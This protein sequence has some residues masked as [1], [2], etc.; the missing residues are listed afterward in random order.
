MKKII[1]AMLAVALSLSAG[2]LAGEL[3][4]PYLGPHEAQELQLTPQQQ[5]QIGQVWSSVHQRLGQ[6]HVQGRSQILGILT[7]Q[8]RTRLA[9]IAG[10]LAIAPNPS[11]DAAAQQLQNALSSAQSQRIL[12]THSALMQQAA[13]LMQSAKTQADSYLTPQQRQK[14]QT[15]M[16]VRFGAGHP[17]GPEHMGGMEH[18]MMDHGMMGHGMQSMGNPQTAAARTVLAVA[19]HGFEMEMFTKVR[20]IN[21]Q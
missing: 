4:A 9:Q 14:V 6:L 18:G 2:A 16:D 7:P 10:N 17:G 1:P 3:P 8:Q 15:S 11:L 12:S 19:L 13:G 5:Q 21:H 20:V